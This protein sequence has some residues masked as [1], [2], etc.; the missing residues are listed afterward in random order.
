MPC[1]SPL[2][3]YRAPNGIAFNSKQG[4]SDKPLRLRCGQCLG[5]RTSRKQD[6]AIRCVH[7]AQM[8]DRNCFLTLTYDD[9]HLPEDHGLR[10]EHFQNFMK[11]VR[12]EYGPGVRYLH[13]GEYGDSGARPHYHALLF[14]L[15]FAETSAPLRRGNAAKH[16]LRASSWIAE[17]WHHGFHSIGRV[18][19]QS[20]AYTASYVVK[21][22]T[23]DLATERYTRVDPE[24]G[25]CWTVP[26][27]YG[28]MS[29]R[30][31][32]G[33]SW[34]E[35]YWNTDC[36][37]QNFVVVNGRTY[38]PPAFY[39]ELLGKKD[40]ELLRRM[41]EQRKAQVRGNFD[42]Y[43]DERLAVREKVSRARANA[44][45]AIT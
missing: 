6:W 21:K 14:G 5:C 20:A 13:A 9:D 7:E 25:E 34:F 3:A 15:D 11:K 19:F 31:G 45:N 32:L 30:P 33:T 18:T 37:P 28:T 35:K 22:A 16:P 44:R 29:R 43:T 26:P 17:K 4:Y 38:R 12:N 24:T 2:K 8:H 41:L 40:P 42:D 10:K 27:E 1:F 23:G 36:Y 39:D